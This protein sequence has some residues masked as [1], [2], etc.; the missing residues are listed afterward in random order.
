M[1]K[2]HD[3][4]LT[5]EDLILFALLQET[6]DITKAINDIAKVIPLYASVQSSDAAPL[7]KP[8]TISTNT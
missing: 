4:H 5:D 3:T 6:N 7:S 2:T 8:I 1:G